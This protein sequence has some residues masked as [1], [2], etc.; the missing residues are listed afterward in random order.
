MR[1]KTDVAMIFILLQQRVVSSLS[2]VSFSDSLLKLS[3]AV[4][5]SMLL[6][7]K[8]MLQMGTPASDNDGAILLDKHSFF[9]YIKISCVQSKWV[10][11]K[12]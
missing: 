7:C 10:G 3:L 8:P 4:D 6:Y 9:I 11:V 5:M 12:H 2:W 1:T